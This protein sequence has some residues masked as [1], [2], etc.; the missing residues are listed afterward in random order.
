MALGALLLVLVAI[1]GAVSWHFS[2]ALLVP[3]HEPGP[4]DLEVL[5]VE[6]G[7]VTLSNERAS[8]R[9][10][11]YGLDWD[12]GHAIVGRV[13]EVRADGVTR[14]LSDVEGALEPGAKVALDH[15]V[16]KGDPAETIGLPYEEVEIE[17][18]L[19]PM[20]AWRVD[21]PRPASTWAIAV[22]GINGEREV[23]LRVMPTLRRAGL[24]TLAITYRDDVGA[25]PSPDGKHHLG[26]TEWRDLEAAARY[27]LDQ[28]AERLVLLGY[29]MGGAIVTQFLERSQLAGRVAGIVLDAPALSWGPILELG[30]SERGLPTWATIPV[31]WVAA[32]RADI[33]WD[34]LDALR[35]TGELR[36]PTLLFHGTQDS[37][38]P[39]QI[40]DE[41]AR[42][43]PELVRYH[44]VPDAD[45]VQ[46]WNVG[47]RAYERRLRAFLLSLG[48]SRRAPAPAQAGA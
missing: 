17:G 43:L 31:R 48:L 1:V 42:A 34:R 7:R 38:V 26:L 18:E 10:G 24:T 37:V 11:I 40:S 21:P 15:Q 22:H 29:S 45:H 23:A 5:T 30:A 46:S 19:G 28:G 6:E 9:P 3:D 16:W 32:L 13:L 33:D 2:S 25:P 44:R 8:D 4:F 41:Y 47:P 35:H 20:P 12:G 27:A 39:V 36:V 14:R